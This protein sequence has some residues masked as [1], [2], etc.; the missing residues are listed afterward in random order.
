MNDQQKKDISEM[1]AILETLSTEELSM[2]YGYA[3]GLKAKRDT[4]SQPG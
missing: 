1:I 4:A 2:T 3:L